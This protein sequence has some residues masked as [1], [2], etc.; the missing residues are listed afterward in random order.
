MRQA[1]RLVREQLGADAVILTSKRTPF[2][3]EVTAAV[4]FDA[5]R[6]EAQAPSAEPRTF[7]PEEFEAP[8]PAQPA[9][10]SPRRE[11]PYTIAD[12]Y[13]QAED[14]VQQSVYARIQA[15]LQEPKKGSATTGRGRNSEVKAAPAPVPARAVQERRSAAV[16]SAVSSSGVSAVAE[17]PRSVSRGAAPLSRTAIEGVAFKRSEARQKPVAPRKA[18]GSLKTP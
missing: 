7:R 2:G 4:D 8:A 1:L 5:A 15:E 9:P 11:D 10:V 13:A 6:V 17:E 3:V 12:H 14:D 18:K 16:S